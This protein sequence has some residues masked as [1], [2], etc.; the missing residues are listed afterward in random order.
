MKIMKQFVNRIVITAGS[1]YLDIDA[2]ACMVAMSE[3]LNWQGIKAIA[4]S[5]AP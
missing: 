5:D 4:Y 2:Y 3:L 1:S